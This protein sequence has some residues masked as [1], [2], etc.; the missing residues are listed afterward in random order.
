ML[1]RAKWIL[2]G[3]EQAVVPKV[4][5]ARGFLNFGT[6]FFVVR[7]AKRVVAM[8][9]KLDVCAQVDFLIQNSLFPGVR[10]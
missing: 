4:R 1:P 3:V 5:G 2:D 9:Y 10:A 8:V 6:E 7:I